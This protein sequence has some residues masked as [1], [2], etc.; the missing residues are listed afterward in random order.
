MNETDVAQMS[1]R[2]ALS[3]AQQFADVALP[4][5]PVAK[6]NGAIDNEGPR[7]IEADLVENE[8]NQLIVYFSFDEASKLLPL[9]YAARVGVG[10]SLRLS[11]ESS[12]A[13]AKAITAEIIDE[14]HLLLTFDREVDFTHKLF[15]GWGSD[16]I[17]MSGEVGQGAAVYDDHNMPVWA[18]AKGVG[19]SAPNTYGAT[20]GVKIGQIS[21]NAYVDQNGNNAQDSGDGA[22]VR[23]QV[24]LYDATGAQVIASAT[25]DASGHY[26]FSSL[27]DGTYMR[28][29]FA[30]PACLH[31]A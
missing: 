11:Y 24:Q 18:D 14:N 20:A 22:V 21:G 2:M 5:S 30:A 26:S 29:T 15:Y 19:L 8:P 10:W 25:T 6:A 1:D 23:L 27:S 9:S 7:V 13:E 17:A 16:R 4:N 12:E 31:H 28:Q 3:I